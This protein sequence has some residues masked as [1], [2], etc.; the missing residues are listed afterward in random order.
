MFGMPNIASG[1]D[2]ILEEGLGQKHMHMY[3]SGNGDEL[4]FTRE[5][6]IYFQT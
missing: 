4:N 6:I 3:Y 2:V 5:L 1:I